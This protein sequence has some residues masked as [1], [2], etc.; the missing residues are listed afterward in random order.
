[1]KAAGGEVEF[2]KTNFLLREQKQDMVVLSNPENKQA[3]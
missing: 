2:S 3:E 1:M